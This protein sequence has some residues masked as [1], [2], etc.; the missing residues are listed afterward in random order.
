MGRAMSKSKKEERC[1]T[2]KTSIE[3]LPIDVVLKIFEYLP[4]EDRFNAS[5][6]SYNLQN[7]F[8]DPSCWQN[9]DLILV[10]DFSILP[11]SLPQ[12]L[13][14]K[15]GKHC[16]CLTINIMD[17]PTLFV[18]RTELLRRVN[19]NIPLQKLVLDFNSF[20]D[21][22]KNASELKSL[23]FKRWPYDTR[24]TRIEEERIFKAVIQNRDLKKLNHLD[25]FWSQCYCSNSQLP[26]TRVVLKLVKH[27]T[28]LQT[29]AVRSYILSNEILEELSNSQ[30]SHKLSLL[31]ILDALNGRGEIIRPTIS[32][33]TWETFLNANPNV[34]VECYS[35]VVDGRLFVAKKYVDPLLSTIKRIYQ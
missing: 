2:G 6:S 26:D 3:D 5:L 17:Q 35:Y 31:K 13:A 21:F 16:R 12:H 18:E 9:Q 19:N 34:N 23:Q 11:S 20:L 32:S 22:I 28:S 25:L 24:W 15:V 29:L 10:S 30:R 4:V 14:A 33:S 8:Y 27:L 1:E 7:A